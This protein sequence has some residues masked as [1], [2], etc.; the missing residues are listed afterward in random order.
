MTLLIC[1]FWLLRRRGCDPSVRLRSGS[2]VAQTEGE[3]VEEWHCLGTVDLPL[4]PCLSVFMCVFIRCV[5]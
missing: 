2:A 4:S 3:R 5:L 1:R